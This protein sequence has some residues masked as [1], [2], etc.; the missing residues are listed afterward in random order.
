MAAGMTNA[1]KALNLLHIVQ[2]QIQVPQV[3][4]VLHVLNLGDDVVLEVQ[5]LKLA[6]QGA[7]HFQPPELAL[8]QRQLLQVAQQPI[9]VLALLPDEL[10]RDAIGHFG[11]NR[12]C[13]SA[14]CRLA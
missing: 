12:G 7:N 6:A 5:D 1:L 3:L 10:L 13:G 4:Q 14:V 11:C 9:V 2:S 8:M